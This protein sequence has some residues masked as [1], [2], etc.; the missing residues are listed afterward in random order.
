M[1]YKTSQFLDIGNK[2]YTAEISELNVSRV[3]GNLP[4]GIPGIVLV[5][6]DGLETEFVY[7][8]RDMDASGE[9][10]LGWH[11]VP[12]MGAVQKVPNFA[13]ARLLIIND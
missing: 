9:D 8:H 1:R 6:P 3:M 12:T 10:I 7:T 13:N 11:F 2:T 4:S 5:S